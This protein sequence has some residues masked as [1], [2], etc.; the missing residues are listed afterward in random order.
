METTC[1]RT[2]AIIF[3]HIYE[4]V[5]G[6]R[7]AVVNTNSNPTRFSLDKKYIYTS[8]AHP[9]RAKQ[10][11]RVATSWTGNLGDIEVVC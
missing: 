2:G 9:I 4:D 6:K 8:Y 10:Y 1:L 5:Y 11:N 3:E 7:I